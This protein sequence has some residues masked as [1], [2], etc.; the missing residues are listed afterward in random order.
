MMSN[1]FEEAFNNFLERR[2]YDEAETAL[3]DMMRAA[4]LAGWKSAGGEPPQ[5]HR[6]FELIDCNGGA[7]LSQQSGVDESVPDAD[8]TGLGGGAEGQAE[9]LV[10]QS[11]HTHGRFNGNRIDFAEKS[12]HDLFPCEL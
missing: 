2:E 5:P 9:R 12:V 8:A 1:E 10:A 7:S 6:I 3:F 11:Q 4:F